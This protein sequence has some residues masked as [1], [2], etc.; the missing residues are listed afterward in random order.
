MSSFIVVALGALILV[1][2]SAFLVGRHAKKR[3]TPRNNGSELAEE[4]HEFFHASKGGFPLS[5]DKL[6]AQTFD[7][8][9]PCPQFELT[10][11]EGKS[12]LYL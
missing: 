7:K 9:V 6:E 10:E 2:A 8:V 11:D 4:P 3:R 1:L 12:N 5:P